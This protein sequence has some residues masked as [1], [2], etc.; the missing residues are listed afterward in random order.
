M[1]IGSIGMIILTAWA[2]SGDWTVIIP[3]ILLIAGGIL[4]LMASRTKAIT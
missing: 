2:G 4:A 1:L 3:M